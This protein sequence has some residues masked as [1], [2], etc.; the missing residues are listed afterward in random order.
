M[1][2]VPALPEKDSAVDSLR[3][4]AMRP[5]PP[6]SRPATPSPPPA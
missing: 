3:A 4:T 2:P 5:F 1:K 6:L